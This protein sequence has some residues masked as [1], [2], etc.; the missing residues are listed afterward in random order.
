MPFGLKNLG[1]TYQKMV[2]KIFTPL[3]GWTMKVY[4]DDMITNSK[5]VDEHVKHLEEIFTLLRK[6]QMKLNLEKFIF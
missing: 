3:I 1:A 5:I 2:N 6:Y 4:V